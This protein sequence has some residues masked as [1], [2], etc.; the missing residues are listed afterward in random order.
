MKFEG[1]IIMFNI[2]DA[3][4][5]PADV[6][7]RCALDAIDELSQEV[8]E[9]FHEDEVLTVLIRGE[10]EFLFHNVS[11]HIN[12]ELVG[13]IESLIQLPVVDR[14]RK[15]ELL[16]SHTKMLPSRIS[17]PKLELQPLPENPNHAYLGDDE[18]LP[19]I[20]SNVRA[21][22]EEDRLIRVLIEHS[23]ALGVDFSRP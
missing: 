22:K 4:R 3:M 14:P 1:E 13:S 15:L 9:L 6:N 5:F 16:E 21:S 23:K 11:Y 2:F 12:D 10:D 20:I 7:Y 19:V 8:N 18:T 17:P